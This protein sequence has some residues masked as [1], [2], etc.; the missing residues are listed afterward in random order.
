[1][2]FR[3]LLG[4]FAWLCNAV[5]MIIVATTEAHWA[6]APV[7]LTKAVAANGIMGPHAPQDIK[8]T[9]ATAAKKITRRQTSAVSR[10]T[11]IYRRKQ[12]CFL[13]PLSQVSCTLVFVATNACNSTEILVMMLNAVQSP[14]TLSLQ[15]GTATRHDDHQATVIRTQERGGSTLRTVP[16]FS[17]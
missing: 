10:V 12:C 14:T 3:H 4:S 16:H 6:N 8:A 11:K 7:P 1:M 9:S 2:F 5:C 13:R 17:P 15:M